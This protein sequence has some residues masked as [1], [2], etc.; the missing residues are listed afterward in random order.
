MRGPTETLGLRP[1]VVGA[2]VAAAGLGRVA[3]NVPAGRMAQASEPTIKKEPMSEWD[4]AWH[5]A[6]RHQSY[7]VVW[8]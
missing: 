8:C 3:S 2:A 6:R 7:G 1:A 5:D 4:L